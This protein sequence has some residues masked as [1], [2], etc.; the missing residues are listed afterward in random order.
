[1]VVDSSSAIDIVMKKGS[2]NRSVGA[3]LMNAGSSR[4]HSVSHHHHHH[5]HRW[6][7]M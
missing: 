7:Q 6:L 5:H 1:M 3:T 2:A 4:S